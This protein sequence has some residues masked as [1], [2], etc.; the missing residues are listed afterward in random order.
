MKSNFKKYRNKFLNSSPIYIAILKYIPKK[1]CKS[2]NLLIILLFFTACAQVVAP[3]G[4]NIDRKAPVVLKYNPDS[5]SLNFNAKKIEITFDEM[6][7]LK[8]LTNQ[9]VISPP[10]QHPPEIAVQNK[11]LTIELD[12]R[13]TLQPN[14]TYSFTFGNS[15]QDITE[16]N[17]NENFK[18]IFSTGLFI[19]SLSLKGKAENAFDH[20]TEKGVIV[21]LYN[22]LSD[23]VVFKKQPDYFAKTNAAGEFQINNI[24]IG[25]YKLVA[26]KDANANYKYDSELET[27]GF[28]DTII[29]VTKNKAVLISMF[30]EPPKKLFIKK[31]LHQQYGNVVIIFNKPTDSIKINPL[32]NVIKENE[33]FVDYSKNKDTLNLWFENVNNDSLILQVKD[34]SKIIDTISFQ[35]IKK[36]TALKNKRNPLKLNLT[37]NIN[38]NQNV[39]LNTELQLQFSQPIFS[40]NQSETVLFKKDSVIDKH[41]SFLK[42][43]L[44]PVK[45]IKL[46]YGDTAILVKKTEHQTIWSNTPPFNKLVP[47]KEHSTYELLIP[48]G[49]FTDIFGLT[50][51]TIKINFKTREERFYGSVKLKINL[52]T[53]NQNY[54]VQLLAENE[55]VV[56][57]N[58]INKSEIINYE[59]L[60]PNKYKLKIIYDL[61]K[62][63]KWDGGNYLKKIQPERV[64]YN[65]ELINIRSNWDMELEWIITRNQ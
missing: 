35:L 29:D 37:N 32:N 6:I 26:L 13:D 53:S 24:R 12:K 51:D 27:I 60:Q 15:L 19:D 31:Q 47:F 39:D 62:N 10:L 36:E 64:L 38:G 65:S 46:L 59:Y 8:D 45:N 5:A 42:P 44:Q 22:D 48:P 43:S 16:N 2:T 3:G 40:I 61:N 17:P 30:Q 9:L 11:T 7:Q 20:K 25:K 1:V 63:N 57:E 21:M 34:G 58:T 23:S 33:L 55:K 18:Y 49:T 4:G 14:T 41:I 54:I 28:A 56:R 50:N 52:P